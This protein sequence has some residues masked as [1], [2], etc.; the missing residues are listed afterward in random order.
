M[1]CSARPSASP[2]AATIPVD[3]YEHQGRLWFGEICLF[4]GSGLERFDPVQLDERFGGFWTQ[5]R[6]NAART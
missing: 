4:P 5:S 3:F 1:K 6:S 2:P